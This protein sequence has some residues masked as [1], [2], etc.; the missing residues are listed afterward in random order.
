MR[1][2]LLR[3]GEG[4]VALW[5]DWAVCPDVHLVDFADRTCFIPFTHAPY[6]I[7]RMP[8]NAHLSHHLVF[9]RGL[10]QRTCF[11]DGVGQ[12]FLHEHMLAHLNRHHGGGK[13][14]VVG[15]TDGDG[16]DLIVHFHQH[17]AEIFV[18]LRL[19]IFFKTPF[20]PHWIDIAEG[21]DIFRGDLIEISPALPAHANTS[22]V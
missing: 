22:D 21:N 2:H 10:S 20:R 7:E 11:S 14:H 18:L 17:D 16:V 3:W 15:R 8:L 6:A 4:T 19:G 5:P 1:G 12:R 9:A 13:V